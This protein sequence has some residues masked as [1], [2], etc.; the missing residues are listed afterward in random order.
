MF[1]KLISI[2]FL[3]FLSSG[4]VRA[5]YESAMAAY[6]A[7]DYETSV[8]LLIPLAEVG[9]AQAQNNLGV[10]Y[11]EGQG[12]PQDYT[13]ALK[14][15]RKAVAQG[16]AIAQTNLGA[17]YHHGY[18]LQKDNVQAYAWIGIAAANGYAD[19]VQSRNYL[20]TQLTPNKLEEA[21][22]L[23][24]ELWDKYGNTG[25]YFWMYFVAIMIVVDVVLIFGWLWSITG[26]QDPNE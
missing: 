15:Y 1:R 7:G 21:R 22:Q 3:V 17:M 13:E 16:D 23:A 8:A 19:A 20:E 6:D 26:E 12:V 24:R 9:D 10:M 25:I 11:V 4:F 2:I 18:G 5:D 14:W